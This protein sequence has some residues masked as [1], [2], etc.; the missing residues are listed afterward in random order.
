MGKGEIA[1][2]EQFLFSPSVFER[3]VLQTCKKQGIVWERVKSISNQQVL[4]ILPIFIP[5]LAKALR[6]D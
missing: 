4:P 1:C 6:A 3:L 5:D 2:N